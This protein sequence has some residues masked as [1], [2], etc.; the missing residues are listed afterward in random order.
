MHYHHDVDLLEHNFHFPLYIYYQNQF[1]HFADNYIQV[2]NSCVRWLEIKLDLLSIK[3]P[4]LSEFLIKMQLDVLF[5][6]SL[7]TFL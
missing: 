1:W 3:P 2:L 6:I 4:H 7:S 5:G